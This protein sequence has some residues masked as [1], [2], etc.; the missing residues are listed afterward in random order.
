MDFSLLSLSILLFFR[1]W[2]AFFGALGSI[3]GLFFSD[4]FAVTNVLLVVFPLVG[5]SVIPLIFSPVIT[6][7]F[8]SVTTLLAYRCSK[9]TW[10]ALVALKSPHGLEL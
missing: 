7:A 2:E 1:S 8:A 6:K 10:G 3:A 9:R 5:G 4:G